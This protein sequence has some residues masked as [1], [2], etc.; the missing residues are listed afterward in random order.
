MKKANTVLSSNFQIIG[1]RVCEGC[2]SEVPII[3]VKTEHREEEVS[4][5]LNCE[6]Q[7]L[8][9]DIQEQVDYQENNKHV[10]LFR[11]YSIIPDDIVNAKFSNYKPSDH[12]SKLE[13]KREAM[14]Y[15]DQFEAIRDS[16]RHSL[17][18]QGSYGLGKSHL[19]YS[20]ATELIKKGF[21]VIFI[22]VPQLLQMFRNNIRS[23]KVNENDIMKALANCDLLILDDLGAE[24]IKKENGQESW[25]VDKL[26]QVLSL[27]NG[28]AKI[29]TTNYNATGLE[30]KYGI[31]GGRIL[32]RLLMG[33]K[34]IKLD[35]EDY[36]L[37]GLTEA[38]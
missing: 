33:T 36:R 10:S 12:P 18:F 22:D 15:V 20:I 11:K 25:A 19:S 28:K 8:Q 17:F 26:F 24:Y 1:H 35:G 29:V 32:S 9:K 30:Q 38:K 4:E 16:E 31:H 34:V 5:C 27:R 6:S 14:K 3:K 2:N 23:Q 21:N 13:A 7:K 37:K